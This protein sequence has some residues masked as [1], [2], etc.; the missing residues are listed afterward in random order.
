[1]AKV[2]SHGGQDHAHHHGADPHAPI[3]CNM[4]AFTPEQKRRYL[5]L[6]KK[7]S[8]ATIEQLETERGYT[9]RAD[10]KKLSIAEAGEW[11]LLEGRCCPFLE[12]TLEPEGIDRLRLNLAGGP[13]VKEF[14][15]EELRI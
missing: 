9:L 6:A 13:G 12:L 5:L 1:M 2:H 10:A 14:L 15:R 8:A 3:A 11:M 4:D 7:L